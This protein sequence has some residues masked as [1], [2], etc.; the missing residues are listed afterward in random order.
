MDQLYS[1]LYSTFKEI[2]NDT[3]HSQFR[4]KM[5]KLWPQEVEEEKQAAEH[6]LCHDKAS[7]KVLLCRNKVLDKI[8]HDKVNFAAKKCW[9]S[10][11]LTSR[12]KNANVA[13]QKC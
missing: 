7:N 2:S 3:S 11:M 1:W 8:F 5:K 9:A 10:K 6:K 12:L 4:V 13:T